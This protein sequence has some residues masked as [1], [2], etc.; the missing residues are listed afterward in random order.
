MHRFLEAGG[1]TREWE[2]GDFQQTLGVPPLP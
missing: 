1:Q 2:L